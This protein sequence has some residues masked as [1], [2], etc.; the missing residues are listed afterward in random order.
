M[1]YTYKGTSNFTGKPGRIRNTEH[2][3]VITF[4]TKPKRLTINIK[5]SDGSKKSQVYKIPASEQ[6]N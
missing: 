1:D 6:V 4:T 2:D 3:E 5:Y